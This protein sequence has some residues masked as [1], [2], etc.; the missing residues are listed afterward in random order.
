M[1]ELLASIRL[2]QVRLAT[3]SRLPPEAR[4]AL[5]RNALVTIEKYAPAGDGTALERARL[6]RL[7]NDL[8]RAEAEYRTALATLPLARLELAELLTTV[9]RL[10]EAEAEYSAVVAWYEQLPA[11]DRDETS[12]RLLS[13]PLAALRLEKFAQ[14]AEWLEPSQ[15]DETP[16]DAAARRAMLVL[17][18]LAWSDS[19][20]LQA[21]TDGASQR[22]RLLTKALKI[23]PDE[24]AV[25]QRLL[26]VSQVK[27]TVGD[28]ARRRFSDLIASGDAP[29]SAYMLAGT[30]AL[31]RGDRD[32]GIRLLEQAQRLN[33][34]FYQ[35]LNNLAWAVAFGPKPDLERALRIANAA[36]EKA[37]SNARVRDTR[38]RIL[39]KQQRWQEALVD[40]ELC[41][42]AMKN[43][44]EY[45]RVIAKVYEKLGLSDV[46]RSHREQAEM[47]V[48]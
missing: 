38:G 7:L 46:A 36:V 17:T 20:V 48:K 22:L 3:T 4:E 5:V 28:E 9:G 15:P 16:I 24:A 37:P 11:A 44:A 8:P 27:G 1:G 40:L 21:A 2:E 14:A 45:H 39:A 13:G 6:H 18:Y 26:E 43:D 42:A 33:P 30:D 12:Q 19:P 29:A 32:A 23:A 34:E 10:T 47:Q 25:L 35:T 41:A 31:V